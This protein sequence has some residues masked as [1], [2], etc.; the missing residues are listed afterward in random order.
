MIEVKS[1]E[2][3]RQE[4]DG[5]NQDILVMLTQPSWCVPCRRLRPHI[6]KLSME[7]LKVLYVDLDDVP[8]AS[9]AWSIRSVPQLFLYLQ[10]REEPYSVDS[11]TVVQI[12]REIEGIRNAD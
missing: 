4:L 2:E 9:E 10:E 1:L 8:E 3:L 6:E 5:A 11:R 7:D 12:Q